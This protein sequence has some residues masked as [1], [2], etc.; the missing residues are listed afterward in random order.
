MARFLKLNWVAGLLM[1]GGVYVLHINSSRRDSGDKWGTENKY[2][3]RRINGYFPL[4]F[5]L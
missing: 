3:F 5:F 1:F 4:K 2:A